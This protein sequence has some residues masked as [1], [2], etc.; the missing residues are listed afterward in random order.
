MSFFV[1]I[2]G[3]EGAGKTSVL[4]GLSS[5]MDSLN[6]PYL[7][8]REPGGTPLAESIRHVLLHAH[9]EEALLPEAE[10]LLMFASRIQHIETLIK[11]ALHS[12]KIVISDRFVDASYAYQGGGRRLPESF[13][14]ALEAMVLKDF[15]PDMTL[16]LDLSVEQA[17][18]RLNNRDKDKIEQESSDFFEHVR[19]SYLSRAEADSKRFKVVDAS[20]NMQSVIETC[21]TLFHDAL[22]NRAL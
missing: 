3:I 12:G 19:Q 22:A 15:L 4:K 11:P 8:T 6:L 13:I 14:Q 16:L 9:P 17:F 20:Q 21:C 1:T 10:L 7:L 18:K 2:E 5:Y